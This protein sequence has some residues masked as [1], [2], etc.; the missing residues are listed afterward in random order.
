MRLHARMI[1]EVRRQ[2]TTQRKKRVT[3]TFWVTMT[4]LRNEPNTLRSSTANWTLRKNMA[5]RQRTRYTK[6]LIYP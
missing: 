5:K 3:M 2:T 4:N 1:R 6:A